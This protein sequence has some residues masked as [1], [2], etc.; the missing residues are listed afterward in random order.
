MNLL[1]DLQ[2]DCTHPGVH[3][4]AY[5]YINDKVLYERTARKWTGNDG[6]Y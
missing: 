4:I 5:M 2:L 6:I 3:E 1:R